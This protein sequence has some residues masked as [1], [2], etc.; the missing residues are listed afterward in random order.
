VGYHLSRTSEERTKSGVIKK[1]RH[2]V[3][4]VE[5]LDK[6]HADL[7]AELKLEILG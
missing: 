1:V 5:E 3:Q 6:K 4:F 2:Y 7:Y